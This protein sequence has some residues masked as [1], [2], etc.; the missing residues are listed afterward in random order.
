M[1]TLFVIPARKGSKG[2]PGKNSRL[3]HDKP[4]IQ[5][6]IDTALSVARP[7][8]ICV[9]TDSP[10]IMAIA[11][12]A[13]LEIPFTRPSELATD[14]AGSREVILHALHHYK[15]NGI[16]YDSIVLLQPTSPFR[17][18]SDVMQMM[19]MLENN[20][21]MV[22]SVKKSHDNPYFSMFEENSEGYLQVV[23]SGSYAR[24]QD[25]PPVYTY[26]GS[27]YVI[28]AE[29]YEGKNTSEF[30]FI[31]KFVMDELHS[32]DIDQPFDWMVAEMIL[33]KNLLSQ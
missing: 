17:K 10:E 25:C 1:K 32:V 33:E 20:T 8:D 7:E 6:S 21:E 22:V 19:Q 30:K 3:L 4:L 13:G 18:T 11:E 5:Y 14:T 15:R 27:V 29:S 16:Q 28:R 23:K 31:K 2:V 12:Q 26:N 9:T 24:R